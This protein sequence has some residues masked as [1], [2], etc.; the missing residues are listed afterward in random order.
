M[1]SLRRG[2]LK[3][4]ALAALSLWFAFIVLVMSFSTAERQVRDPSSGRVIEMSNH[5]RFYV[6]EG[7]D[8]LMTWL[9]NSAIVVFIGGAVAH[10]LSVRDEKRRETPWLISAKSPTTA[11]SALERKEPSGDA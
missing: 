11:T 4:A 1:T 5:G 7:E 8:L 3:L 6:T 10:R 9:R 2:V